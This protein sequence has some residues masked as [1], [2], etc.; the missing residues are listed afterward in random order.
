MALGKAVEPHFEYQTHTCALPNR[1]HV[2]LP[3]PD[4]SR[5]LFKHTRTYDWAF[6]CKSWT[7]AGILWR[8][9]VSPHY[10]TRKGPRQVGL[11]NLSSGTHV[12][13]MGAMLYLNYWRSYEWFKWQLDTYR[14]LSSVLS[15]T[16]ILLSSSSAPMHAWVRVCACAQVYACVR[17]SARACMRAGIPIRPDHNF[18]FHLQSI[19]GNFP[20]FKKCLSPKPPRIFPL[21]NNVMHIDVFNIYF[22]IVDPITPPPKCPPNFF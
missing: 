18:Q 5:Y 21:T 10:V 15:D 9:W 7:A 19:T 2:L 4:L 8:H 3:D 13:I 11:L 14:V 17:A 20:L 1:H 16:F 22:S 6:L 12:V